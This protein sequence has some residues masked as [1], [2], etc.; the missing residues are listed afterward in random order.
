M[1]ASVRDRNANAARHRR[2]G[3]K[4]QSQDGGGAC[5]MHTSCSTNVV[6]LS[7]VAGAGIYGASRSIRRRPHE[8]AIEE[9]VFSF[10]PPPCYAGGGGGTKRRKRKKEGTR[11]RPPFPFPFSAA[12]RTDARLIPPS[13]TPP[14]HPLAFLEASAESKLAGEGK[15]M[16]KFPEFCFFP[17]FLLPQ[18]RE[19][20]GSA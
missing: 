18:F 19:D 1:I 2:V 20:R 7:M 10:L 4:K 11:L 17:P 8:R 13:S 15:T 16:T 6:A 9:E 3:M 12:P 5:Q 14:P